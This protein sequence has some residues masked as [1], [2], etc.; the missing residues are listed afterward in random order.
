MFIIAMRV[1]AHSIKMQAIVILTENSDRHT[2]KVVWKE[3]K[4]EVKASHVDSGSENTVAFHSWVTLM[5]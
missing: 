1:K 2:N 5:C 3:K 4:K